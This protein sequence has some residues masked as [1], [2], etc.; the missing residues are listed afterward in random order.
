MGS[1]AYHVRR[2]A[3]R[4]VRSKVGPL[5]IAILGKDL[6][7]AC[8]EGIKGEIKGEIRGKIPQSGGSEGEREIRGA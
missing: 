2:D 1:A 8:L 3:R 4:D 5:G 7:C 6:F